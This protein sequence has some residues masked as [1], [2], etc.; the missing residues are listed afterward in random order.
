M[1]RLVLFLLLL[2]P[3][4]SFSQYEAAI[5]YFGENAGLDFNSG[6]PVV[7]TDGQIDTF[8]GCATISDPLGN[9]LFYTD[10]VTVWDSTHNIMPNGTG[11]LGNESSTQSAIIVPKPNSLNQYYIF[12]VDARGASALSS[13]GINYSTVDLSLNG[14]LGDIIKS[15]KNVPL[16]SQAYEKI[17]AVQHA[18]N[19]SFWVISFIQNQFLAWRVDATGVNTTPIISTVSNAVDSRGYLKISPNGTKIACANFGNTN[20]MM[21]YDFNDSTGSVTNEVQLT[22]DNPNDVPYGVE[23]SGQSK[24]LYVT[25]SQLNGN[26][27]I[28]PG[29]LLQYDMLSPTISNSRV[30]IHS[31]NV[32]TRGAIQL[33]I[34]GKIY[35]ALSISSLAQEGTIYLGIINNPEADG[36]LCNYVHDAIDIS[37]G[38][39]N[40]K[41]VEGLPPFI[42]S[43][44][45][46]SISATDVCF[47][48]ATQFTLNSTIPPT[49]V[50]WDFGDPTTGANNFST[51][52]NPTHIFS[53]SGTFTVT[54][55]VTIGVDTSILTLNVTVYDSPVVT[56]PVTLIQ[57]DDDLD[58]IVDFN[59]NEANQI[60]STNYLNE[61]FTY[62]LT[63]ADAQNNVNPIVNPTAF[64][65][66]TAS[67]VWA[68]IVN[69][70][71]CFTTAQV[72]LQVTSTN[73]PPTLMINFN[74]CDT[75][76]DGD[77]TNGITT[78]DFSSAT[79]Q[80]ETALLPETNLAISYYENI[81]DALAELNNIDPT[82]YTNT[83][84][85]SQ[86][87]VVRVDDLNN[88]CF[89]LGYHI[90]L[91]VDSLPKFDLL[92][93][94][95]FCFSPLNYTIGIQN[96]L[97]TYDYVWENNLGNIIGNS[98]NI[99]VTSGG[100][101]SVTATD[102]SGNNCV[103][104][105][106]IQVIINSL[107]IITSPI[108]LE[109]CDDD[110]DGIVD[111][112]LNNAN[113][114]ISSNYLN[115][116][117]TYFLMQTDAQNNVNPIGNPTT[118][119]NATATT[120]WARIVNS[121]NCFT[122]AEVIL[123]VNSTEIPTGLMINYS[124]CDTNV[125]GDDTNGFTTFD[126]SSVTSQ[127]ET[128]LLPETNLAISYYENTTDALAGTN[129]IDPTNY[130]NTTAFSQ[131]IAVRVENLTTGCFDVG[132][133]ITLNVDSLPQFDLLNSI[134]FCFSPLNYTIGIQ[135]PL[136]S[137]DYVWKNNLGNIIGN[138][139][140]VTVT[141]GGL[142]SVTATDTSGNNCVKT[143]SI[144]VIINSLPIVTSPVLLGKCDDDIDGI[145]DFNL[146]NANQL[147]STNY[148]NESF[149]YFLT[150]TDAQN[151]T[152]PI[153]N[154]LTFTNTTTQTVWARVV[155]SNN[156]FT[157]AEVN[158]QV[159]LINIPVGLMVNF[160]ECDDLT[161]GNDT[162]GITTFDFSSAT[163][164]ILTALLPLNNLTIT[165]YKN[166]SDALAEI[167][168][169]DPTNYRNTNSP[170]TQQIV[171]RVNNLLNDCL[172]VGYHVTLNVDSV[173]KFDLLNSI[174]F[175]L[176]SSNHIVGIENPTDT[177]QYT[178]RDPQGLVIGSSAT[179]T[180]NMQGLHTVIATNSSNNCIKTKSIQVN[181]HNLPNV[182]TPVTLLLC[183]DDL[184]GIMNFDLN[185]ADAH[186]S[187]NHL[188][189]N[190]T[191]F[192]TENN[193]INNLNPI[194]N[195]AAFSN[196]IAST[197]WARI[198]NNN[199]CFTTA[200]INLQVITINIPT[201]LM[202]NFNECDDLTDDNDTNGITT[203]N[204]ST[205]TNQILNA[206]LPLDNISV[207]YYQNTPD[208]LAKI[209][210]INPVNYRNTNS[211]F[212]Q[213]IF[214]RIDHNLIGCFKI[215]HLVTLNVDSVPEFDL[216]DTIEFCFITLE[217]SIG[218]EN[219]FDNYEYVWK[220]GDNITLGETASIIINSGGLYYVTATN[221]NNCIKTKSIQV[222][223]L[224]I[225]P[226]LNFDKNNI[227]LVDNTTNNTITVL[228][229]N[230]PISTYEFSI[231]FESF[232]SNNFFENIP[233]GL[234]TIS[235]RDIE[236]C[237]E[238]SIE[239]S[240]INIPNFFTP[241]EDSY[242]DTW[243]VTGIE[244]QPTSNV[245]IF[246]RFGKLIKILDPLGPGWNGL[247][248]SNPLPST[249]YWYKVELDD[250][251]VLRGHFS[252]IRR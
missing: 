212:T 175:C 131:Q 144:Q 35:R 11:L 14:N 4:L 189:E 134:E 138:S 149:T 192:L 27:H 226:L 166:I 197:V 67:T 88:D 72:I 213:D 23:F 249:D 235:I 128:A 56:S 231:D 101:Y 146:N 122:T 71:N 195:S 180:V 184:D 227:L 251:R 200:K 73:I 162:N 201:N 228:T 60:I 3:I 87:I 79:S 243:H 86:Q 91:N 234:H 78:F 237:L 68:R 171:I 96:P 95:E 246:D 75:D 208:A 240:V 214:A 236:N 215:E 41:V 174:D 120:V 163:N 57:C 80:I 170:Y 54:A 43:F 185:D 116:S 191:Y 142:Y 100:L 36:L 186:I 182:T 211:P 135:N 196:G 203:F 154:P 238:S 24:K 18:D 198:V 53:S 32:N 119:S 181:F 187:T 221:N 44:F 188:N 28:T 107:P 207:T 172:G 136:S 151:N 22:L 111:F 143:K 34:D 224:P 52:V 98:Q 21:I 51:L 129:G 62:F 222:I 158:L 169:I 202:V 7:L 161:D 42:Q 147:I 218:I 179:V 141:S 117:F 241:N 133:H 173:P 113:Q 85:F 105:K 9:L 69:N 209:N 19:N 83:T 160:N 26:E 121:N 150:Q 108:I 97:T 216:I 206:M 17:T 225:E 223:S 152:N 94:I 125:D 190:F 89:G 114:L 245:Y 50:I 29:K 13:N 248:K 145:V 46:S 229:D 118:F 20:S 132:Y 70:V 25:T 139:P 176:D 242:N 30:L 159:N 47:G 15:E 199:N 123:Q 233:V 127:I 140:N 165:Y 45:L 230:L 239:V 106:N 103:K 164:Q 153:G 58:G 156:C 130:T 244:F 37:A 109:K 155:N 168:N 39:P 8:E 219:P 157:T 49:S 63:Q 204:F 76:I 137:Y 99:T 1:K 93:S 48:D 247:Y 112:N 250:G 110:F 102:T 232:Q 148:L 38:N 104:T 6:V 177:Y 74:E 33:A 66:A 126:F 92:N 167:N 90:T 183:D 81:T 178:W 124:E 210:S 2:S 40:R 31:S 252:L 59:L 194:I 193:A 10:G 77:D 65:N 61:N 217:H 55:T 82:N 64:S 5:W 205:A 12:T 16:I 220:D 115:E 84:A